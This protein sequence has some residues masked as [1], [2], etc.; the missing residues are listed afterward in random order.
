MSKNKK[1]FN[2]VTDDSVE[3]VSQF[4]DNVTFEESQKVETEEVKT[5]IIG[6][7]TDCFSLNVREKPNKNAAIISEL[8]VSSEVMIDEEGSTRDFYKICTATGI[9][10]FCMKK[11]ITINS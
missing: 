1:Q 11:F 3:E 4:Q 2:N 6:I 8:K 9:E 5:P 7:V 10:G